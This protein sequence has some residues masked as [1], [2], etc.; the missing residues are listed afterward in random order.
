MRKD[1]N[2]RDLCEEKRLLRNMCKFF[3]NTLAGTTH[4]LHSTGGDH[5]SWSHTDRWRQTTCGSILFH[6]LTHLLTR[7]KMSL[8]RLLSVSCRTKSA[9]EFD[10]MLG[11][12]RALDIVL[13]ALSAHSARQIATPVIHKAQ[14]DMVLIRSSSCEWCNL[15]AHLIEV[16]RLELL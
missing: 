3:I 2:T 4:R 8:R 16:L 10:D 6:L 13:L 15:V 12:A 1:V 11:T 5:L 7:L 14:C 9:H